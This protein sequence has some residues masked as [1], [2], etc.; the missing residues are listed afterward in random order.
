MATHLREDTTIESAAEICDAIMAGLEEDPKTTQLKAPWQA[1]TTRAET[2]R[3]A[4]RALNQRFRRVRIRI[5][6]RDAAWDPEVAAFGRAVVDASAGK[7]D[8]SPYLDFFA[9]VSPSYAQSL[10]PERE[11]E[12]GKQWLTELAKDPA[13]P[14]SMTWTPR[15]KLVNDSLEQ[16]L[17][18]RAQA[19][20]D[21]ISLD[22]DVSRLLKDI[23]TELDRLE[24]SLLQ[25]FPGDLRRIA[26]YLSPTRPPRTKSSDKEE[27]PGG[28]ATPVGQ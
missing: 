6:V 10:G 11:V 3:D 25:L 19:N 23:N 22:T 2:H 21:Q 7:R 12:L 1:L 17:Q 28:G 13:G 27:P 26:S 24:G 5:T 16:A 4:Q 8:R 14:L 15:L 20:K 9:E 18:D